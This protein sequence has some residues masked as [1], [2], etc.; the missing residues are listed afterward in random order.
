[1]QRLDENEKEKVIRSRYANLSRKLTAD[2][3]VTDPTLSSEELLVSIHI[4][5]SV[6]DR[7]FSRTEPSDLPITGTNARFIGLLARSRRCG[8]TLHQ[9]DFEHAL[10]LN[11]S[12]VSRTLDRMEEMGL[13]QRIPDPHDGRQLQIVL[14]AHGQDTNEMLHN[15]IQKRGE[16]LIHGIPPEDLAAALRAIQAIID[17]ARKL[18]K[19]AEE[20]T[21]AQTNTQTETTETEKER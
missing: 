8:R 20:R 7:Y 19:Q 2:D 21:S 3:F 18:T 1:M 17:N 6:A 10:S 11:R 9:T 4:V 16:A 14:T 13:V 5:G 15:E 12:T